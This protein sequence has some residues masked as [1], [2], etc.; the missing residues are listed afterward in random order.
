MVYNRDIEEP[1]YRLK[2]TTTRTFRLPRTPLQFEHHY[3]DIIYV[4]YN[5]AIEEP[6]NKSYAKRKIKAS[7][8]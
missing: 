8:L 2:S 4:V 3:K 5:R 1:F 6:F 7:P